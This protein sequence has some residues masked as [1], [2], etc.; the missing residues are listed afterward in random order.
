MALTGCGDRND[1]ET[2]PKASEMPRPVP[3][4]AGKAA[5]PLVAGAP[6]SSAA[7]PIEMHGRWGLT[8]ADC[9]KD[10]AE[11]LLTV[12][13]DKLTFYESVGELADV[14]ARTEDR[15]RATFGFSGE[16][17][18][19]TRDVTLTLEEDGRTLVRREQGAEASPG[20]FKYTRCP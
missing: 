17:M 10:G 2:V 7:I 20:A 13:P 9:A 8:P 15:V 4:G 19:W 3:G 16:G 6:S 14:T 1:E 18:E 12:S 11:G 5:P